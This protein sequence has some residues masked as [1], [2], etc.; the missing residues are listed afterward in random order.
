MDIMT[1][2]L[3]KEA[4]HT[5]T[6]ISMFD[7]LNKI[8]DNAEQ[9]KRKYR[10][11]I[12]EL[13]FNINNIFRDY[14]SLTY[15]YIKPAITAFNKFFPRK[16]FYTYAATG[17]H[18]K[19]IH[20]VYATKITPFLVRACELH[21]MFYLFMQDARFGDRRQNRIFHE[22]YYEIEE[23]LVDQFGQLVKYLRKPLIKK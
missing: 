17:P 5:F 1:I 3:T 4:Q 8:V 16:N 12:I 15:K 11:E 21:D 9:R 10:K 7:T 18:D 2:I 22:L 19:H 20:E 23:S 13:Y 6:A 14:H